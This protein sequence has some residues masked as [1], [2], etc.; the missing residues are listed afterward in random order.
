MKK[1]FIR[2]IA[3][4]V[5]SN[6]GRILVFRGYDSVKGDYFYRPLGGSIEF[7]EHSR[8]AIVREI[9]E[10]L[11]AELKSLE[12]LGTIESL[13]TVDGQPGHEFVQV[14]DAAFVDRTLYEKEWLDAVENDGAP[15]FKARWR[16]LESFAKSSDRLVPEGLLELLRDSSRHDSGSSPAKA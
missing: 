5:F 13:F 15:P 14:Y 12:L 16:S 10:E 11:G 3:I 2:A 4:C 1:T 8:D 6:R 9:R 7:G